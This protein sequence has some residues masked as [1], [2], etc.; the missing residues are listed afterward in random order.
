MKFILKNAVNLLIKDANRSVIVWHYDVEKLMNRLNRNCIE[1][2]EKK[3]G[4]S[5]KEHPNSNLDP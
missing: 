1:M 2:T 3:N 5:P 4:N